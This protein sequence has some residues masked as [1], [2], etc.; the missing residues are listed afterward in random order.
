MAKCVKK[1]GTAVA[2][3][4]GRSHLQAVAHS[5]RQATTIQTVNQVRIQGRAGQ[6]GTAGC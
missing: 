3:K 1:F 2:R 6:R 4:T 5:R